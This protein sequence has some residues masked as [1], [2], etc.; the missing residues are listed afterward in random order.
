[1]YTEGLSKPNKD[2]LESLF[3][4]RRGVGYGLQS[5]QVVAIIENFTDDDSYLINAIS[6]IKDKIDK[7]KE[8]KDEQVT[9]LLDMMTSVYDPCTKE[10]FESAF[11]Y[12]KELAISRSLTEETAQSLIQLP[13]PRR[14]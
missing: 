6:E 1:M 9:S 8:V 13:S 2:T 14:F 12:A 4:S 10:I 11:S 5:V 7:N 3:L